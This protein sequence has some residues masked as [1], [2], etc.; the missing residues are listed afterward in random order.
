MAKKKL[1]RVYLTDDE[2]RIL[3]GLQDE[4]NGKPDKKSCD[5]FVSA[6]ALPQIQQLNAGKFGADI[7]SKDKAAKLLWKRRVQVRVPTLKH[8][9]G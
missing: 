8:W 7:I 1:E 2:R 6:E 3:A 4:W 9:I 5:A